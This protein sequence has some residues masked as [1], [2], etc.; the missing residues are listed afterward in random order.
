MSPA[1]RVLVAGG[2]GYLGSALCTTLLDAGF[3][4]RVVDRFFFGTEP[5]SGCRGRP[6]FES[7]RL[8][9]RGITPADLEGFDTVIDIAGLSNDPCCALDSELTT[10]VNVRGGVALLRAAK[11]AGVRRYV[12]QSSCSVY[13]AGGDAL[14]TEESAREPLTAYAQSKAKM[15]DMVLGEVSS[16][17]ATTVSRMGTL[18][19]LSPRMRFDLIIN[20]MTKHAFEKREVFVLGG[21]SQWRPLLH[22]RDGARALLTLATAPDS[23]VAGRVFN[24]G[25][26]SQNYRVSRV[27]SMVAEHVS[28]ASLIVVPEDADQRSYRVSFERAERELDFT[29]ERT[30]EDGIREIL[31]ALREQT[32]LT[33][34]V[35]RTVDY[36]RYLLD[37]KRVLDD[38]ILDGCL[39]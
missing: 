23:V 30:P 16:G 9:T 17:F 36:Y 22:V 7:V 21:G 11:A 20:V 33:G 10:D 35:T 15:E 24:M 29:C 26:T 14:L 31:E 6:G 27:A 34:H 1:G 32:V 38:V 39:L 5:L 37:A 8:D 12:Y 28:G 4:V 19:G 18:Y 2:G 13:G 3:S 25:A